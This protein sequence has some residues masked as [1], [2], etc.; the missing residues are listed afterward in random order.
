MN[1]NFLWEYKLQVLPVL[2]ALLIAELPNIIRKYKRFY[3]IPIYF[4]IFP[5]REL[6]HDLAIYLGDDYFIKS[7]I[8]LPESIVKKTRKKIIIDSIISM[9]LASIIIPSVVGFIFS[10]F[11]NN[12]LL[13]QSIF[14]LFLYKSV[15]I[16]KAIL[17]F[18][19]HAV[20][21]KRNLIILIIIYIAYLGV[22]FQILNNSYAWSRPYILK[23]DYRGLVMSLSDLIFNKGLAQGLILT[24]VAAFFAN[25]ITDKNIREENIKK[26]EDYKNS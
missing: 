11:L 12:D 1:F 10:F 17:G 18:K 3:Y 7:D 4:I 14:A 23:S 15:N 19:D 2:L 9:F 26:N 22:F 24:G 5:L 13:W 21:T 20:A 8:R 25:L 6:N 16:L